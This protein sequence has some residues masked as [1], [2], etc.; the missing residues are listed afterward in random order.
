M[1]NT[2]VLFGGRLVGAAFGWAGTILIVRGLSHDQWGKFTFVFSFLA[3]VSVLFSV[4]SNRVAIHGLLGEDADRFAGSYLILRGLLG[5][6]GYCAALAFVVI[7]GYPAVVLKATAVGGLVLLIPSMAYEAVYQAHL[8]MD[9]VALASTLGQLAQLVLTAVLAILGSTVVLFTVPAVLCE[10][11]AIALKIR[12]LR[13]LQ[14]IRYVPDVSRWMA[15]LREAIP[16]AVGTGLATLYYSLDTVMLSKLG[17]F[18][19]VGAY[20]IAYKFAGIVQF[21]PW[22][23]AAPLVSILVRYWPGDRAL[24]AA[25]VRRAGTALYL[26]AVPT[27]VL[28]VPFATPAIGL[29]YGHAYQPAGNATR[30][31]IA[32]ECVAFFTTLAVMSFA[33][34]KRNVL[35]SL[36][37]ACGLLVNLGLNL[38]LIPAFSYRGAAWATLATEL[39]VTGILWS[40]LARTL[41]CG[42]V[43]I[44][45]AVK[46]ALAG[47]GAAGVGVA[48]YAVM[49]WMPAAVLTLVCYAAL[50]HFGR[51]P[52]RQGLGWLLRND[53]PPAVGDEFPAAGLQASYLDSSAA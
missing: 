4:V 2:A 38:V 45:I 13:P 30:L 46:G 31:V 48:A 43:P 26:V 19:A 40:R 37:A 1:G 50:V 47:L 49:P 18:S 41:G 53:E 34:M 7:A 21:L 20:G 22:A 16:L 14:R 15:M 24:F 17:T 5:L 51:V 10:I 6:L 27:L 52:G 3:I 33:A 25:T 39:L 44:R 28:F 42:P 12:W 8:Q 36:A 23:M 9:R 29:L 35:Y 32:A 11:V